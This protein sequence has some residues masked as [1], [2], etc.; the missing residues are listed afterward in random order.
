MGDSICVKELV[1]RDV[2]MAIENETYDGMTYGYFLLCNYN[3]SVLSPHRDGCV[4][5]ARNG[6]EGIFCGYA[7]AL[8]EIPKSRCMQ[9]CLTLTDLIQPS[10][11]RED[12]QKSGSAQA[13]FQCFASV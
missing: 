11:R 6:L 7:S 5:R 9:A 3:G 2:S 8:R 4:P 10:L 13:I 1:L 12:G